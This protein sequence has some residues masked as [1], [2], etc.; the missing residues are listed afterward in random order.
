MISLILWWSGCTSA[1]LVR[2]VSEGKIDKSGKMGIV[3]F[4]NLSTYPN[5]GIIVAEAIT[6]LLYGLHLNVIELSRTSEVL[7]EFRVV[8]LNDLY[9]LDY[10]GRKLKLHYILYGYVE[11]YGYR[12]AV[13][14]ERD[15][16]VITFS[17]YI[18]D[19]ITKKIVYKGIFHNS[20]QEIA[21]YGA[22]P[23]IILLRETTT[24]FLKDFKQKLL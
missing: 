18:Y 3:V 13:E 2:S 9:K 6:S 7:P 10:I 23:L 19:V 21:T 20:S 4:S 24:W 17:V 12:G 5:A 14:G 15:S 22:D 8:A 11:E 1:P 16:P